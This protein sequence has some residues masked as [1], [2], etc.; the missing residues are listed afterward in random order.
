MSDVLQR[1][2][3]RRDVITRFSNPRPYA[4]RYWFI[5]NILKIWTLFN[6]LILEKITNFRSQLHADFMFTK[7]WKF[8]FDNVA[9]FWT[10]FVKQEKI[11]EIL[12]SIGDAL[13]E[14]EVKEL[15]LQ[16]GIKPSDD[17]VELKKKLK[18][19][20][21]VESKIVSIFFSTENNEHK[22]KIIKHFTFFIFEIIMLGTKV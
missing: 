2:C 13:D 12:A 22:F 21:N 20:R 10:G 18:Y 16:L 15:F 8:I 9:T 6:F 14:Q 4:Q 5:V 11:K 19:H 1:A 7:S 17:N 3:R